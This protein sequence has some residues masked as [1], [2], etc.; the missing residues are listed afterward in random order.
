[1]NSVEENLQKYQLI[2]ETIGENIDDKK[3][4][5]N[6]ICN[7][8]KEVCFI[9]INDYTFNLYGCKN[10]HITKNILIENFENTQRIQNDNHNIHEKEKGNYNCNIHNGE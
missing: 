1:M 8:C 3:I 10:N 6:I 9:G 7:I 4:S 5:K 2:Q